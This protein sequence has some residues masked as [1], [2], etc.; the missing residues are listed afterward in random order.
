MLS[1][2]IAFAIGYAGCALASV[3]ALNT[4]VAADASRYPTRPV[5]MI[6]GFTPGGGTDLAAR[7]LAQK[8]GEALGATVIVDNRPGAA[9]NIG[10]DLVAKA[11]PDGYT[12]LMANS[13]IAIPSLFTKLPFDIGRDFTPVSLIA[14]GPSV[15]VV[16]PSLAAKD[17][18]GLIA[19]AKAKPNQL[20]YGSGG[21][22]NITHLAME[23]FTASAGLDMVHI[24]YKGSS[25]SVTGLIQGEVQS[26]FTS[27][28]AALPHIKAGKMR[29]L[30]VSISK[31]SP[32][33]PDVP[34]IAE[35][36]VPGYYAASWYGLLLPD[37]TPN[38][39]VQ[40]LSNDVT[41][42]MRAPDM[43]EQM[44]R[45]GFEPVGNT[46]KEFSTF[47]REETVRWDAVVK[48]AGIKS[49]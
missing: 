24:P 14:I 16:N 27:I 41:A 33:L 1:T 8:L 23:L 32:A 17:V 28:P 13:T 7:A 48:K 45:Q 37:G 39:V 21:I 20:R 49:E 5:R 46:P 36:G 25:P 3:A 19:L 44:L 35:S 4:A 2:R 38:A 47:I 34:T 30:G 40:K 12:M 15:L 10:A 9:G 6:V 22:G 18:K 42:V 26:L 29:P 43:R 31:R 11:T